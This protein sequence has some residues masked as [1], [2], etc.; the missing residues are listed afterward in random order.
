[1][2]KI[3]GITGE[4]GCG[5]T[6]ICDYICRKYEFEQY[7]FAEPI[8][9][10]AKCFGFTHTELYGTQSQKL[11]INAHW[12]I[13]GR[14]FMQKF[15]TDICRNVLPTVIPEMKLDDSSMWIKLY[16]INLEEKIKKN[17]NTKLIVSDV[18]FVNESNAIQ[19]N[20]NGIIIRVVKDIEH[21]TEI[22]NHSS[23]QEMK[24]ISP[25]ITIVNNG[26]L[27][28]LYKKIDIIMNDLL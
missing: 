3:L 18:R 16:K 6:T 14:V 21:K 23:E 24:S 11:G 22:N 10:I 19:E 2:S 27:D 8:K 25:D 1:M 4:I 15:G 20:K 5:K 7:A 26:S 9:S 17:K 28:E 13:S 12:G